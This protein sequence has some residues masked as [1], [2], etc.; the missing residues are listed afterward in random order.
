M[1][2][3][4]CLAPLERGAIVDFQPNYSETALLE[5]SAYGHNSTVR[6]LLLR[7]ASTQKRNSHGQTSLRAAVS[8]RLVVGLLLENG[9]DINTRDHEDCTAL[10]MGAR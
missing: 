6:Q 7:G 8:N 3:V 10:L 4:S 9:A 1:S 5:A 2:C